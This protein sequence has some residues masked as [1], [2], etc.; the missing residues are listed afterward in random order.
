MTIIGACLALAQSARGLEPAPGVLNDGKIDAAIGDCFQRHGGAGTVGVPYDNGGGLFAHSWYRTTAQDFANPAQ[1][2]SSMCI[3]CEGTKKAYWLSP[4]FKIAYLAAGGIN[5]FLG[6]PVADREGNAPDFF[7]RFEGGVIAWDEAAREMKTHAGAWAA[8]PGKAVAAEDDKPRFHLAERPDDFAVVV[9]VEKYSE[10]P[11]A[12]FAE[13][14]AKAVEAH[15][16]ALG[17]PRRNIVTLSGSKAVRSALEKYLEEWLP[18]NV[19]PKSRVFF[20]FSGHGAPDVK[21]GSAYLLP[22]DGDADYLAKTA[23]P[24]KRLYDSLGKLKAREVVVALDACFSGAGGRSLLPR[25]AR[26][27]V[28]KVEDPSPSAGGRVIS[29]TAAAGNQITS[30]LPDQR[31]GAFTYYFLKGLRGGAA[32]PQGSVTARELYDYLKPKVEDSA[33]RQNREQTPLLRGSRL[34]E[35]L[36]RFSPD[37]R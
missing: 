21:N 33:R 22:W 10:L 35:E 5:S 14:D 15:L 20:Y 11:S 28:G 34:D 7:Q 17:Y 26:P 9:G 3:R 1:G 37:A 13:R 19:N 32:D 8:K 12:E 18:R 4:P 29:F 23:Y 2:V 24:V 25:G 30:V 36:V 16:I 27:L 31:H 6:C